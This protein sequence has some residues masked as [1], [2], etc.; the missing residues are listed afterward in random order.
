MI[1]DKR[2]TLDEKVEIIKRWEVI[3]NI[4][5]IAPAT[6]DSEGVYPSF[7]ALVES[8]NN[9]SIP[10]SPRRVILLKEISGPIGVKSILKSPVVTILP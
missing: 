3:L 4:S 6:L 8:D 9:K 5:S 10:S 7:S 2:E 1:C